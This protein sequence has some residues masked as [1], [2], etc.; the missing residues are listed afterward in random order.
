MVKTLEVYVCIGTSCHLRGAER[1]AEE[2]VS[3]VNELGLY[4]EVEVKGSFCLEH[5]SSEGVS[6]RVGDKFVGCVKTGEVRD[7]LLPEILEQTGRGHMGTTLKG[8]L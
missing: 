1:I 3:L 2:L 5:C 7:R 4:R 6:T 8:A